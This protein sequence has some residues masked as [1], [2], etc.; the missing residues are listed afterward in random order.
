MWPGSSIS[1][2]RRLKVSQNML[3][4]LMASQFIFKV[5][6]ITQLSLSLCFILKLSLTG[7]IN[8]SQSGIFL[9][10]LFLWASSLIKIKCV[11]FCNL[12][13]PLQW[14]SMLSALAAPTAEVL[15]RSPCPLCAFVR[16]ALR[17][18]VFLMFLKHIWDLGLS[19]NHRLAVFSLPV[20]LLENSR[21]CFC[22][23]PP[24][25]SLGSGCR[26]GL[27]FTHLLFLCWAAG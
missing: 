8:V 10:G 27:V 25:F 18:H 14:E 20:Y 9:R 12:I 15:L 1:L 7:Y 6:L 26:M 22:F 3:E 24:T 2:A 5:L 23:F 19:A 13:W 16:L 17:H 21:G 11:H 4:W